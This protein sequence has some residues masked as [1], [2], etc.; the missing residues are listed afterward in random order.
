[1]RSDPGGTGD[2]IA[3]TITK[4]EPLR[5]PTVSGLGVNEVPGAFGALVLVP[6][7]R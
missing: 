2:A 6:S 3:S 5:V 7:P 4:N 1:M